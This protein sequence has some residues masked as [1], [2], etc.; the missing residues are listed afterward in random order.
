MITCV[1]SG[2]LQIRIN[3]ILIEKPAESNG[4]NKHTKISGFEHSS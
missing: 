1:T 3:N 4:Y 2:F